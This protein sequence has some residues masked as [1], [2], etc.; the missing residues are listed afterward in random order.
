[1]A[2]LQPASS[3]NHVIIC[4]GEKIA[5]RMAADLIDEYLLMRQH[6]VLDTLH[7]MFVRSS[8]HQVLFTRLLTDDKG[9]LMASYERTGLE[10]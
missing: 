3:D 10:P 6:I 5:A 9:G 1:M 7:R 2:A 8:A 4:T